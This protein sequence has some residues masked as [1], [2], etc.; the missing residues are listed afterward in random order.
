MPA[1]SI[2]QG[3]RGRFFIT[4][5]KPEKVARYYLENH[6]FQQVPVPQ[7]R[8][9]T[10]EVIQVIRLVPKE[11]IKMGWIDVVYPHLRMFPKHRHDVRTYPYTR[12]EVYQR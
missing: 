4:R 5:D 3:I 9:L 6:G 10:G 2:K 8:S 11:G 12:L 1:I 7:R